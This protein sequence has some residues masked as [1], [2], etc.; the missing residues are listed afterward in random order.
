MDSAQIVT[1]LRNRLGGQTSLSDM[2]ITS[3][4]TPLLPSEGDPDEQF[5]TTTVNWLKTLGGNF[6]HDVAKQVN[7]QV[8]TKANEK[9]E[10]FKSGWK[11]QSAEELY[12]A[13]GVDAPADGPKTLE[14]IAKMFAPKQEPQQQQ[15]TGLTAE[16]VKKLIAE[17]QKQSNPIIEKLTKQLEE[18]NAEN[19][20]IKNQAAFDN[21]VK[22][23]TDKADALNVTDTEL[24]NLSVEVVSNNI[25]REGLTE[26]KM[27]EDVKAKFV[28]LHKRLRPAG[29]KPFGDTQNGGGKSILEQILA[30]KKAKMEAKQKAAQELASKWK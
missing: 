10:A 7:A 6:S 2:T 26:G 18:M 19:A 8:E 21:I 15:T 14:D 5:Y 24:W 16:D 25:E 17:S 27:L 4:V 20:R 11:P 28:E 30:D 29:T 12:K 9:F 1:E 22:A 23:V 3:L 13:L